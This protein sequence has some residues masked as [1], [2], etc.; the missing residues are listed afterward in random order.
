MAAEDK[1]LLVFQELKTR[2]LQAFHKNR[3]VPASALLMELMDFEMVPSHSPLHHFI[4]PAVLLT[5]ASMAKK[6]ASEA[7]LSD[8]LEEAWQRAQHVPGGFCGNFGACGAGVG[9]GI[10]LSIFTNTSPH[11]VETWQWCS[12][13]T[14]RSL[15]QISAVP[16]P[17]CC[18]RTCFL[19]LEAA[20]PYIEEK[21]A[22]TFPEDPPVVCRYSS[23]N[24][25]C[26]RKECPFYANQEGIV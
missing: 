19:A 8:M 12:E 10:F 16:G 24:E 3:P 23:A 9:T 7:E 6:D 11:S 2:C 18:K 5:V 13:I 1:K 21:C 25:I 4:M 22:L 14:A 17:C 20:I 26:K 15:Q